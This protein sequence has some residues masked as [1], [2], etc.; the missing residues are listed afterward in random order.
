MEHVD[1]NQVHPIDKITLVLNKHDISF[2]TNKEGRFF[3][4]SFCSI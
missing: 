3:V 4:V 1:H 2:L